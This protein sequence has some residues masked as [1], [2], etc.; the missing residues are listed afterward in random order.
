MTAIAMK[1]VGIMLI[2]AL[3]IIPAA[4]A[5][6]LAR[7]PERMAVMAAGIR[8]VAVVAGLLLSAF[9]DAP[10]GLRSCCGCGAVRLD[11]GPAEDQLRRHV[12]HRDCIERI[13]ACKIG[14]VQIGGGA[15]I[16]VQ[17]MTNTDTADIEAT[18]RQIAELARAG[19]EIVRITVDRDEVGSGGAPY[20]RPA[21]R[22]GRR[23]AARRRLPL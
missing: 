2:T 4:A 20:P 14:S 6:R 23:R 3:L 16:V 7:S 19:S 21:R 1:I 12:L 22:D 8:L 10:R 17:S 5:R 15:P 13:A 11:L 9:A 18:A